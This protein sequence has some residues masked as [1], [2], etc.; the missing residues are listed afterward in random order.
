VRGQNI[1]LQIARNTARKKLFA[2]R[3]FAAAV[4]ARKIAPYALNGQLFYCLQRPAEDALIKFPVPYHQGTNNVQTFLWEAN[5]HLFITTS[6]AR[7]ET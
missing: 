4:G 7:T 3:V 6:R 2:A 5:I 1:S